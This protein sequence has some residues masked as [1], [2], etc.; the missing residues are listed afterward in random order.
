MYGP[1]DE[2]DAARDTDCTVEEVREAWHAARDDAEDDDLGGSHSS[3]GSG[4]RHA[5]NSGWR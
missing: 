2:E 4:D 1:Y 3:G 5:D